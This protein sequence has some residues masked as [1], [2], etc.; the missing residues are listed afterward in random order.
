MPVIPLIL[1]RENRGKVLGNLVKNEFRFSET[2]VLKNMYVKS[3]GVSLGGGMGEVISGIIDI[4]A[5]AN[6][7]IQ[8]LHHEFVHLKVMEPI[9]T[10][11]LQSV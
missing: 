6:G 8:N 9:S 7:F 3:C 11:S 1:M 10:R 4:S 2:M 5:A